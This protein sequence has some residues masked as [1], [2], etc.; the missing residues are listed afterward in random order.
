MPQHHTFVHK[1]QNDSFEAKSGSDVSAELLSENISN[2]KGRDWTDASYHEHK[3]W[4]KLDAPS[5]IDD[6]SV[7]LLTFHSCKG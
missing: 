4:L 1:E 6:I 3:D 2:T 5:N 7:T